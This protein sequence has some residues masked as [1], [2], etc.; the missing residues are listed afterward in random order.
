MLLWFNLSFFR[1]DLKW[2]YQI[3]SIKNHFTSSL[4]SASCAFSSHMAAY[5]NRTC[6]VHGHYVDQIKIVFEN[7]LFSQPLCLSFIPQATASS[8]VQLREKVKLFRA[9]PKQRGTPRPI[10]KPKLRWLSTKRCEKKKMK[11]DSAKKWFNLS[12]ARASASFAESLRHIP[13]LFHF[14]YFF[15]KTSDVGFKKRMCSKNYFYFL[16]VNTKNI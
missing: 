5:C 7:C 8:R 15:L 1:L 6:G 9:L 4:A 13:L 14:H 10:F 3:Q 16:L 2:L 12:H 11:Y